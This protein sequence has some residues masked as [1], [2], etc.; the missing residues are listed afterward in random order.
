MIFQ[1][2]TTMKQTGKYISKSIGTTTYDGGQAGKW[3]LTM[4][5]NAADENTAGLQKINYCHAL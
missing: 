2:N 5:S 1:S 4:T 3:S